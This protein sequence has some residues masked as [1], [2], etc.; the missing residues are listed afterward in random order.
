VNR[1]LLA[2][3][4]RRAGERCEYCL[5]PRFAFP[6]P[7]QIDHIIAE[8]H[9]GQAV[10]ENLALACPHCNRFKGPNIAGIDP[11]TGEITRLYNPRTDIWSKHFRSAGATL[12]GTTPIGRT[13]V[14]VLR[15]NGDDL[16]RI[17]VELLAEGGGAF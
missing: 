6:L 8:K 17:R 13:T 10:E 2:A 4:C 7:F 3:I 14:N 11:E 1:D 16:L 9:G 12:I 5:V 15:M